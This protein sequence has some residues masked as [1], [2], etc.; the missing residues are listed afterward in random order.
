MP[1][2]SC[3]R[4]GGGGACPFMI[5]RKGTGYTPPA[6]KSAGP[7][8]EPGTGWEKTF[9]REGRLQAAAAQLAPGQNRLPLQILVQDGQGVEYGQP[10]LIIE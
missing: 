10:I 8:Q 6:K 5:C 3:G 4:G 2:F 1:A 9:V 7:P